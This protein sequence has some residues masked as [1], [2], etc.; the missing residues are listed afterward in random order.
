[1]SK[2]TY[3]NSKIDIFPK[4]FSMELPNGYRIDTEYD[5]E[6]NQIAHLR[7][8]FYTNDNGE[9][10]FEFTGSFITLNSDVTDRGNMVKEGKLKE[11]FVPGMMLEQVAESMMENLQEQFGQGKRLNLYNAYP[12][13]TI[14]KFYK[15]ISFFG[16]TIESYVLFYW[17]EITENLHFGFNTVYQNKSDGT[18][19]DFYKH[20]L[21]VI[22]SVRVSGK[23]VDV[24][25]LTPKKLE[26]AL[27]MDRDD[28]VEA[29]DLGL[30]IGI[31]FQ[32]DDGETRYTIN[33]D[34]SITSPDGNVVPGDDAYYKY[35]VSYSCICTDIT[36]N[37]VS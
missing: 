8:G 2:K 21:N 9:E 36:C 25:N 12:A 22:K 4:Q 3:D 37:I 29:M 32:D 35:S 18:S 7:G 13:S 24:G 5:D 16:V 19:G 28:D 14:M 17:V 27:D 34:G 20:L 30:S 6:M 31:N 10:D 11:Q 26:K 23:A 1:M 15:P 33:S